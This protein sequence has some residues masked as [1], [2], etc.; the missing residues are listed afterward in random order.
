MNNQTK[1]KA[2]NA[3]SEIWTLYK[4]APIHYTT[5]RQVYEKYKITRTLSHIVVNCGYGQFPDRG[6][7]ILNQ[8]PTAAM[9]ENISKYQSSYQKEKVIK[10]KTL[11]IALLKESSLDYQNKDSNLDEPGAVKLLKSLG[12]KIMKPIQPQYEEI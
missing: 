12:Y 1:Q 9:I 7:F 8:P 5:Q 2:F 6:Y 11:Q 10:K 3:L 4:N